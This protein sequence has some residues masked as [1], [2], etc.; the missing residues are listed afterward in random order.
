MP[1]YEYKCEDCFHVE[2]SLERL[3]CKFIDCSLCGNRAK[4]IMSEN[5][6]RLRGNGWSYDGYDKGGVR[7]YKKAGKIHGS[8]GDR[9]G[10]EAAEM[11]EKYDLNYQM[12]LNP[13]EKLSF[14][15]ET[16]KRED[17]DTYREKE[18]KKKS[19]ILN[20][21]EESIKKTLDNSTDTD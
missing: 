19:Y 20:P 15:D 4:R 14:D 10:S 12:A 16:L 2:E 7:W 1:L 9:P 18:G 5:T 11:P 3:N 6:F 21:G 13:P 17:Y 8:A